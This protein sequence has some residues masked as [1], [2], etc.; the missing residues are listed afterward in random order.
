MTKISVIIPCYNQEDYIAECLDS[1]LKQTF[2][3]YEVIIVND[4]ST[5]NSEDIIKK[6]TT[7]NNKIRLINQAN[8]GVVVARNNAIDH[9]SGIY[10]YPLDADDIITP[11]CLQKLYDVISTTNYRVVASE[12][13]LFGKKSG[14]FR[15]PEFTKYQMYGLHECC[16]VSALFYKEDFRRFGGYKL[17]FNGYGG[18]DMDYWL[19]Y[20]DNDYPML[21]LPEVLFYYRIKETDKS[22]WKNYSKQEMLNRTKEKNMKL[23][24]F[25]P[26]MRLW[27]FLYKLMHNNFTKLFYDSK[28]KYNRLQIK[29]LGLTVYKGKEISC[30]R[31]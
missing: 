16:V 21:R 1:V 8:Q 26:K 13:C 5:D 15:Q 2:N 9:A 29:V 20:I 18:D 14:F 22:F 17:D 27:S 31:L 25:H 7:Q 19:N 30:N 10:V 3:D 23:L 6:Y 4:G 28:I 11:D 24:K 12:V